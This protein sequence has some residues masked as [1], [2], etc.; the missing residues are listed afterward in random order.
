MDCTDKQILKAYK[1]FKKAYINGYNDFNNTKP[2][3]AHACVFFKGDPEVQ[4]YIFKNKCRL[5]FGCWQKHTYKGLKD[6][7]KK[8]AQWIACY[9]CYQHRRDNRAELCKHI[10]QLYMKSARLSYIND[11]IYSYPKL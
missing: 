6:A 5:V 9:E 10:K 7:F 11:G 8:L 2:G 4:I 1:A 3:Q